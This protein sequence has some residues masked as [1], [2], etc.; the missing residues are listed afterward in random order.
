MSALPSLPL[1]YAEPRWYAAHTCSR[2][3]KS[4]AR[5]LELN[6]IEYFLPLYQ[7]VHDW[8]DRRMRV[9]MPLFPGYVF[10]HLAL[11]DRLAVLCL[12]GVVRLVGFGGTPTSLPDRDIEYLR[13]AAATL[14]AEPHP[15]LKLGQRVRVKAGPFEGLE[16]I[17]KSKNGDTR[18][19][20]TIDLIMRSIVLDI[21]GA[22]V[23]AIN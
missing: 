20:I 13:V 12:P 8:K 5:Q 23:E 22:E 9:Q 2:H 21:D 6:R 10:V 4:V 3:E 1:E 15:Y 7:A 11:R 18:I 19:V 16:G 14:C 17:L